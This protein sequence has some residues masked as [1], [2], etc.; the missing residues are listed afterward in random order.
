MTQ[1]CESLSGSAV[2]RMF[3]GLLLLPGPLHRDAVLFCSKSEAIAK[4]CDATPSLVSGLQSPVPQQRE[5]CDA[6]LRDSMTGTMYAWR[7]GNLQNMRILHP[8]A[9]DSFDG[10]PSGT[11]IEFGWLHSRRCLIM[12]INSHI[13]IEC[14]NHRVCGAMSNRHSMFPAAHSIDF[15]QHLTNAHR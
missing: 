6:S 7:L 13:G 3:L 5:V 1:V 4:A 14:R 9:K 2:Q 10:L 8:S 11:C 15:T 12:L